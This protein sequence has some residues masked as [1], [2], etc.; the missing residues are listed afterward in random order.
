MR[1][2]ACTTGLMCVAVLVALVSTAMLAAGTTRCAAG[3]DACDSDPACR[4]FR[5]AAPADP[6][7][8]SSTAGAAD[9]GSA[10]EAASGAGGSAKT[11]LDTLL[12]VVLGKEKV[13]LVRAGGAG[14]AGAQTQKHGT[15]TQPGAMTAEMA[16][17][18]LDTIEF[19]L[20]S[21]CVA[22]CG[23]DVSL[24][25]VWGCTGRT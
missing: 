4:V 9:A 14:S 10:A 15:Q 8:A 17:A 5:A 2:Q 21:A 23:G 12:D 24:G 3:D 19:V 22:V 20:D 16:E 11:L 13:P 1:E 6:S 18:Q 7:T 25:V